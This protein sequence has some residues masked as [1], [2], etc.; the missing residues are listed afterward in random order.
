MS[1]NPRSAFPRQGMYVPAIGGGRTPRAIVE[2][3]WAGADAP[4][5]GVRSLAPVY[6]TNAVNA[7]RQSQGAP[8][9]AA[10]AMALSE[11][12]GPLDVASGHSKQTR[13]LAR[14]NQKKAARSLQQ[15]GP[16]MSRV[17]QRSIAGI[18]KSL[19]AFKAQAVGTVEEKAAEV[20]G[21][22]ETPLNFN[23]ERLL[24]PPFDRRA[25]S[26]PG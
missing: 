17:P 12:R 21:G 18:N 19:D 26:F 5:G 16:P 3:N 6:A 13:A 11:H 4:F 15:Q 22:T 20:I 1:Y 23:P 2:P 10:R 8:G 24:R 7:V 25:S 9:V 14:G